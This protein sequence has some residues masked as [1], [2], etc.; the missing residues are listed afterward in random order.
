[1]DRK[2]VNGISGG[3]M[4]ATNKNDLWA[5]PWP[6]FLSLNEEFGFNLDVC[7]LPDTAK[8][9]MFYGP[10]LDGLSMPWFGHCW[11]NPPYSNP[12][13]W[14]QKAYLTAQAGGLVVGL[15]RASVDTRWFHSFVMKASEIRFIVD[16]VHFVMDGKGTRSNHPSMVVIW[17][18]RCQGP[19]VIGFMKNMVAA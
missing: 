13:P 19:P 3:S 11:M 4:T 15:L 17:R 9:A 1:M 2:T 16:R 8:C 5:T 12:A 10:D 7:A 6:F 18:P 14:V